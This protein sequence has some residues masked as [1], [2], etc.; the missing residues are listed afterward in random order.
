[1]QDEGFAF[2][3]VNPRAAATIEFVRGV[4]NSFTTLINNQFRRRSRREIYFRPINTRSGAVESLAE[5]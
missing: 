1:M 5:V 3:T 4:S 2:L